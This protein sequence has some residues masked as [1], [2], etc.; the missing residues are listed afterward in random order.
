MKVAIIP[1]R[2]GSQRIP[3]KNVKLFCGKPM[4]AWSIDAAQDSN[5]FDHI[6]CSTD[7]E[8]IADVAEKFGAEVPFLRPAHL[9]DGYT[10]IIP[11]IRHAIEYLQQGTNQIELACCIYA[12]APFIQ[13]DDLKSSLE[14]IEKNN[15]D[16]CFSVTSYPFPNQRS[17]RI[18]ED[19]R[20]EMF[21]PEMFTQRSQD[22]EE[23][24]HDA[25]QFC[26]GNAR[27]WLDDKP[28]F[29]KEASPYL[30]PR[31]R[32]QDIDTEED[33]KRAELMFKALQS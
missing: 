33:W 20:C 14:Q 9:S 2:G 12:T 28:I 18:I 11:V 29:S 15:A 19:Q 3:R 5:C 21:Q 17:I 6:I 24:Y 22:L 32:V 30:L 1:A 23:V 16:Y 25:G 13:S 4:I 8:E 26:W 27:A 7:D 10:G 31:Y